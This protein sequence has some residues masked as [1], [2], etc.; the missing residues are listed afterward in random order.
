MTPE[1][2]RV[3]AVTKRFGGRSV[4]EGLSF[5]VQPGEVFAL[6]G[7]NGAG[8]TTCVRMLAGI[9]RPDEGRIAISMDGQ[10]TAALP[11]ATS[12]YLPEDR[13]LYRDIPVLRTLVYFGRL[14]GLGHGEAERRAVGWL[15]RM[16][17][18]DRAHERVDALSKGNQQRVQLVAALIHKPALA[19]LDE[20]FS[21]L[22]PVSQEFFLDLVREQRAAGT[23][24]LLSAHQMD[25][26]ERV[27]DR[28]L[29]MN[30]GREI[31]SGSISELRAGMD[32]RPLVRLGLPP[33]SDAT[34]LLSDDVEELTP[35]DDGVEVALR[36]EADMSRF[37][38]RALSVL[39]VHTIS[40]E[41][42]RLHDV[43]VSAVR[44][45]DASRQVGTE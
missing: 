11:P 36:V 1:I 26:V 34:L 2:V 28:I 37:I 27:A 4:V 12:A 13:G 17:L 42:T 41:R 22:D 35:V 8:K 38:S 23:T 3:D 43:F 20:P 39:P 19:I 24:I 29:L 6:L 14:R 7:P 5:T 16:N 10:T 33:G 30:R 18:A 44:N 31:L 25:L 40:S 15:E 9:I 21:G 45:D 32:A